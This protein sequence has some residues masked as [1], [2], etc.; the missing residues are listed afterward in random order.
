A[1]IVT[2]NKIPTTAFTVNRVT[3]VVTMNTGP[4]T[5][6]NVR[7]GWKKDN[8]TNMTEI[9]AY[10]HNIKFGA[11]TDSNVFLFG[12][13]ANKNFYRISGI[14]QPLYYPAN[15]LLK[16]GDS[17]T[18]ITDMEKQTETLMI[19]KEGSTYLVKPEVNQDFNA[20]KGLNPYNFP[21]FELNGE[22]GC[23]HKGTAQVM[24]NNPFTLDHNIGWEWKPRGVTNDAK[25]KFDITERI[26]EFLKLYETEVSQPTTQRYTTFNN[27]SEQELYI[28]ICGST[29]FMVYNYSKDCYYYH[30]IGLDADANK[31]NIQQFGQTET[32]VLI[33]SDN[34]LYM[35]KDTFVAD[36][37]GT[38][39]IEQYAIS[40]LMDFGSISIEKTMRDE[41][42]SLAT[43]GKTSALF[44]FPTNKKN[45]DSSKQKG[46][47]SHTLNWNN[48]NWGDMSW[49]T[50]QQPAMKN[51]KLRANN[52]LTCRWELYHLSTDET[53][54]LKQI[55]LVAREGKKI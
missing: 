33:C 26:T 49:N 17:S 44:K 51:L 45:S 50:N 42:I 43:A 29:G 18:G 38:R 7:I 54:T 1:L 30:D 39:A 46:L 4:A 47:G 55:K 31:L 23:S 24:N 19:F 2:V 35:M 52:F 13:D 25:S 41:I 3:G 21:N 37:D 22:A 10:T 36:G 32:D 27:R 9:L 12:N 28:S 11:S 48:I 53:L 16:C 20:N 5:N 14:G 6:A 40:T 15:S 34:I 8:S